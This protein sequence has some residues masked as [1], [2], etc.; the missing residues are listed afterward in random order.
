MIGPGPHDRLFRDAVASYD[1]H[2]A[3]YPPALIDAI[4]ARCGLTPK[5]ALLDLG[6]GPGT[7]ARAFAGCVG[8]VTGLDPEPAMI[9]EARRLDPGHADDYAV[10]SD[11]DLVHLDR[12]FDAVTIGRALHWMDAETIAARLGAVLRLGGWV[13]IVSSPHRDAPGNL[14]W[15]A[16][17]Q[18]VLAFDPSDG[19]RATLPDVGPPEALFA[20]HGFAPPI[21]VETRAERALTV[22]DVL[23]LL[24]SIPGTTPQA[25]GA[26]RTA[27]ERAIAATIEPFLHD[28]KVTE[29]M[30]PRALLFERRAP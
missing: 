15:R 14:W 23:G 5:S 9:A 8:H 6:C 26:R 29:Y 19:A 13:A 22:A 24:H 30:A 11:V 28:G 10:G 16:V 1:A 12:R 25:L 17:R 18:V 7:L 21:L 3:G 2:R 20:G 27:F 4:V